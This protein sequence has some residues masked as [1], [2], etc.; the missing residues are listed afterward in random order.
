MEGIGLDLMDAKALLAK[1]KR[2]AVK[3][4]LSTFIREMTAKELELLGAAD[5]SDD[6]AENCARPASRSDARARDPARRRRAPPPAAAPPA[7][8]APAPAFEKASEPA[9][10]GRRV[11]GA[12]QA[13]APAAAAAPSTGNA[14][15]W[16]VPAYGWEQG[17]YNSPWVNIMISIDGVVVRLADSFDLR[18]TDVGGKNYRLFVEALDKDIVPAE[19][20]ILVKKNR[21]TVKLKKVKGEYSYDHWSDLKKKGGKAAKEKEKGRDPS[22]GIMD[23]MKDLYDNGDDNMRKIIGESMMKSQRGEKMDPKD[24]GPGEDDLG[25]KEGDLDVDADDITNDDFSMPAG[26]PAGLQMPDLGKIPG[27]EDFKMPDGP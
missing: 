24:M 3:A 11:A 19:S 26:L 12:D 7:P 25:A 15:D 16:I 1:A 4:V 14:K 5:G 6:E 9:A 2:P 23:M 27:M 21:V 17:E 22:A 20:K 10:D 18:I 8:A 13:R